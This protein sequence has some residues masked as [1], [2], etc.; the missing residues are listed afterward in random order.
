MSSAFYCK[1]TLFFTNLLITKQN[2]K[3]QTSMTRAITLFLF[4]FVT[5][6]LWSGYYSPLLLTLGVL[7]CVLSVYMTVRMQILDKEGFPIEVL[8]RFIAYLPWLLRELV[9][10]GVEISICVLNPKARIAPRLVKVR[11]AQKTSVGLMIYANSITLTP[12][13]VSIDVSKHAIEVHTL[14]DNAEKDL[15]N[16]AMN[17]KIQAIEGNS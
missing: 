5:W 10:S 6:I 13:T 1:T 11:P 15:M 16:G 17:N 12:G 14:T 8:L 7:S 4:L 3:K 2:S 9:K